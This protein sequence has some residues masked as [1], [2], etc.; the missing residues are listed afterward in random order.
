M[1]KNQETVSTSHQEAE[2]AETTEL[3][4][5][6]LKTRQELAKTALDG[7]DD[8]DIDK[9][10]DEIDEVLEDQATVAAFVQRGGQ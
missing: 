3:S 9:I 8:E 1:G 6:E 10:L 7:I 5:D 2:T 4:N